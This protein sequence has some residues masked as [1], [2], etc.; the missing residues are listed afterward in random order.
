MM[1]RIPTMLAMA[2]MMFMTQLAIGQCY[3]D[4]NGNQVCRTGPVRKVIQSI[5]PASRVSQAP[6]VYSYPAISG[7]T[8]TYGSAVN[9]YGSTGSS[10]IV[11]SGGSS[12]TAV[13]ATPTPAPDVNQASVLQTNSLARK[14]DFRKALMQAAKAAREKG[15]ITTAQYF[16]IAAMSRVPKVLANLEASMH[17]AAIEEGLATTAAVD[18]DA[19]IEFIEKLIPLIIQLIDL[20]SSNMPPNADLTLERA[21][22]FAPP[23]ELFIAA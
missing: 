6:T 10:A 2:A 3:I 23:P 22:V 21:Y 17:E 11:V 18:W 12:G 15:E 13:T 19:I 4:A 8:I 9:T 14:S 16:K 1:T 7:T 5:A 20:F